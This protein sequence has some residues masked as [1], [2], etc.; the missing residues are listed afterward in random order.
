MILIMEEIS[1]RLPAIQPE[2]TAQEL[3]TNDSLDVEQER[4]S[5]MGM[6]IAPLERLEMHQESV[7]EAVR[8]YVVLF[9]NLL[10]LYCE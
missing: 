8:H 5:V 2:R 1:A 7:Q 4:L 9:L 6:V 3:Q 10:C